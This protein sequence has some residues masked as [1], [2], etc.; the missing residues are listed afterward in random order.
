MHTGRLRSGARPPRRITMQER[1][2]A[3]EAQAGL[4]MNAAS[5]EKMNGAQ[6]GIKF[7]YINLIS[8]DFF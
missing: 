7:S 3:S 1:D 5:G 8:R 2:T 6:G 4:N